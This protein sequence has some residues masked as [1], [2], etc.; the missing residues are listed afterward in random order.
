ML[1]CFET[2]EP[3]C[4][5]LQGETDMISKVP[6]LYDTAWLWWFLLDCWVGLVFRVYGFG[7]R[8]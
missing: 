4:G 6:Y 1:E 3:C 8:A 2:V 7:F 5:G